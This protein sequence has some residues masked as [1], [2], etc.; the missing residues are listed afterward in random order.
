MRGIFPNY[1]LH[2]N[3]GRILQQNGWLAAQLAS[4]YKAR[5][6]SFPIG[7]VGVALTIP[8]N[9][10]GADARNLIDCLHNPRGLEVVGEHV[11]RGID[12]GCDAVCDLAGIT[13]QFDSAAEGRRAES[14]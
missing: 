8:T 13:A 7:V 2:F 3:D 14:D 1:I 5:N 9:E 6:L 4:C 10:C 12:I 11:T